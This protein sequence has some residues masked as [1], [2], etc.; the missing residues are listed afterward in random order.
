MTLPTNPPGLDSKDPEKRLQALG[1]LEDQ[2]L[3]T[4]MILAVR[5][6][7]DPD[8][9]VAQAAR[10]TALKLIEQSGDAASRH[11]AKL[12]AKSKMPMPADKLGMPT[13]ETPEYRTWQ[14]I[15]GKFK[16]EAMFVGLAAGKAQLQ[17]KDGQILSVPIEKLSK[18]DQQWVRQHVATEGAGIDQGRRN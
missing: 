17:K 9:K 4:G 10:K 18:T 16:I 1:S 8:A 12:L 6:F 2:Q 11:P 7:A 14:D 3:M 5:L 15:T 13:A